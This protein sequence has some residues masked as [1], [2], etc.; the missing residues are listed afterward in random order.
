MLLALQMILCS[1]ISFKSVTKDGVYLNVW[2]IAYL[3]QPSPVNRRLLVS[4]S[5]GANKEMQPSFHVVN[6]FHVSR[7][8]TDNPLHGPAR[9]VSKGEGPGIGKGEYRTQEG[10][11]L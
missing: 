11:R 10:E 2:L 4:L 5:A 1:V 8:T 3:Y 9:C 7:D 6:G